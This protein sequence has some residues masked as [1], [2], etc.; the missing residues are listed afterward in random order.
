[1]L[2]TTRDSMLLLR[3]Y[4]SCEI[5]VGDGTLSVKIAR[6]FILPLYITL[7]RVRSTELEK[8]ARGNGV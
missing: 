7:N 6:V 1:M 5:S 2:V 8:W 4:R 3:L